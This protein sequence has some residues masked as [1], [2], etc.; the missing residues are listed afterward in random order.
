MKKWFSRYS[1][2]Y[3]KTLVYMFQASEYNIGDFLLWLSR[4]KDFRTVENRKKF[5]A[6]KKSLIL[7]LVTWV[8]IGLAIG[9]VILVF[10]T[11]ALEIALVTLVLVILG[12]PFLLPYFITAVLMIGRL[13]IQKPLEYFILAQAKKKL[14]DHRGFKIAVAGSFG[15]TSMREILKTVLSEGQKV[16]APPHSYNTP[17]GISKFIHTLTGDEEVIIFEFGEYY[18]GDIKKLCELVKP[19]IGIITGV[20][21]A[22]LEKLKTL[23]N[24]VATIFELADFL[25]EEKIYINSE[26][27]LARE[28][29]TA[30]NILYSKDGLKDWQTEDLKTSLSGTSFT[31]DIGNQKL[32]LH[33]ELLGL[34]QVG[35]LLVAA[36]LAHTLGL[37]FDQ[38]KNGVEK[39]KPF[40]HRLEI[41]SDLDGV[42]TLDDSYNGNP[43]GVR[44][45]INFLA[46]LQNKR[47]WYVT[48]GLVEMGEKKKEVHLNIG[49]LLAEANIEKVVLIKNSATGFIEEGLKEKNYQGEVI[50]FNDAIKAYQTLPSLTVAGDV[51][52]L[53][54]DW[55]DQYQ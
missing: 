38:I 47:R 37:T 41:K 39:T 5:T 55:P 9:G 7:L 2:T 18:K 28:N 4:V 35:P 3:P 10:L 22:H 30:G 11:S 46:E 45:V 52:L 40:D 31:V 53:Q 23:Q 13:I 44:A 15:K 51:V 17:L 16:S 26:S 50:W 32:E 6:T 54:N 21:E 49:Y 29:A 19:D 48:P 25:P 33:S 27:D 14:A 20:N 8:F 24:T 43:D 42:V 1:L 34:H 12:L 36:C